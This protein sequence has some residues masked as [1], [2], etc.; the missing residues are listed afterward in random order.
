MDFRFS[1]P[2]G[3]SGGCPPAGEQADTEPGGSGTV[4]GA[5]R[6]HN[7]KGRPKSFGKHLGRAPQHLRP[8]SQQ[9]LG[10][11]PASQTTAPG[12]PAPDVAFASLSS[13]QR[14]S[15]ACVC[16]H[17]NPRCDSGARHYK[18]YKNTIS[19]GCKQSI[20]QMYRNSLIMPYGRT[21]WFLKI[22]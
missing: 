21:Y 4:T 6:I 15:L 14:V 9:Q 19:D 5:R 12:P 8:G 7:P 1:Q 17:H 10:D 2:R 20:I 13:K 18:L 3:S 16:W 22:T 11:I